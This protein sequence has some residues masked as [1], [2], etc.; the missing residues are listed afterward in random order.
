MEIKV[1]IGKDSFVIC[2]IGKR[3]LISGKRQGNDKDIAHNC[4]L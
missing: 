2:L 1:K 3:R 4:V